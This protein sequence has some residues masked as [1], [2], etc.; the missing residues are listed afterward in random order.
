MKFFSMNRNLISDICPAV[1]KVPV[2]IKEWN[3]CKKMVNKVIKVGIR[4]LI[5]NF[6][7]IKLCN[8]N[9]GPKYIIVHPNIPPMNSEKF[10]R[11]KN[12]FCSLSSQR[13]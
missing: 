10:R 11:K 6:P 3:S 8:I 13:V 12:N 7:T 5:W 1:K 2:K 9:S 4:S